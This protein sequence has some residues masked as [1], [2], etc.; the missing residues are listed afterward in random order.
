MIAAGAALLSAQPSGAPQMLERI[1]PRVVT[2]AVNQTNPTKT[3]FGATPTSPL[4]AAYEEKIRPGE[5]VG[6]ELRD[7]SGET[8]N[9]QPKT[10][11]L[12]QSNLGA[13][14][15]F[16]LRNDVSVQAALRDGAV[17]LQRASAPDRQSAKPALRLMQLRK[18]ESEQPHAA[19][20]SPELVLLAIGVIGEENTLL[21]RVMDMSTAG[22]AI[23]LLA[24]SGRIDL[25]C[26]P[27]GGL[28]P[29]AAKFRFSAEPSVAGRTLVY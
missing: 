20:P 24:L 4:D 12:D 9:V 21:Y 10:A 3:V 27:K 1:L 7:A 13:I 19:P 23:K 29:V 28:E 2:V 5:N 15:G 14:A 16:V 26:V 8:V 11:A 18:E 17:M 25:L 6:L 22:A